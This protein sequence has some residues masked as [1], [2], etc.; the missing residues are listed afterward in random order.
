MQGDR[1]MIAGWG[2]LT[3]IRLYADRWKFHTRH[4]TTAEPSLHG[5]HFVSKK[6]TYFFSQSET[7][8]VSS[9]ADGCDVFPPVWDIHLRDFCLHLSTMW[10]WEDRQFCC[11]S[12]KKNIPQNSFFYLSFLPNKSLQVVSRKLPCYLSQRSQP[13][14]FFPRKVATGCLQ[15]GVKYSDPLL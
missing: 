9:H 14:F 12:A 13:F 7:Q 2:P 11:Q 1:K 5:K 6:I 4:A 3:L 8:V 15:S 10:R